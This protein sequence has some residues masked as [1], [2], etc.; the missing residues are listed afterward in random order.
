MIIL[1]EFSKD[2]SSIGIEDI[3]YLL[4][5]KAVIKDEIKAC[6]E[7]FQVLESVITFLSDSR[8]AYAIISNNGDRK[9]ARPN[10]IL[11]LIGLISRARFY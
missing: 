3:T 4:D 5:H 6:E 8:E 2:P 11:K 1:Q 9:A 7:N 10:E